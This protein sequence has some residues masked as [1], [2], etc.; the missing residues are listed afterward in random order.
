[1]CGSYSTCLLV[2]VHTCMSHSVL[3]MSIFSPLLKKETTC[4]CVCVCVCVHVCVFV[5]ACVCV[6][7]CVYMCAYVYTCTCVRVCICVCVCVC[8]SLYPVYPHNPAIPSHPLQPVQFYS[9]QLQSHTSP[10]LPG[11]LSQASHTR[12]NQR[13]GNTRAREGRGGGRQGNQERR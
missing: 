12:Y 1:M 3:K 11:S 8:I 5:S 13:H 4:V 2:H 7:V 10:Y 6:C 9:W